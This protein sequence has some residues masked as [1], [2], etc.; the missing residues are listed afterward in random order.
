[1]RIKSTEKS[2]LFNL[3]GMQRSRRWKKAQKEIPAI[4]NS[5]IHVL[6]SINDTGIKQIE[7]SRFI[8][9]TGKKIAQLLREGG[10]F[11]EVSYGCYQ[12][13]GAAD[14]TL[15]LYVRKI[16]GKFCDWG[17]EIY[18]QNGVSVSSE[19]NHN[20]S[21]LNQIVEIPQIDESSFEN[22]RYISAFA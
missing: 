19:N 3:T 12:N 4:K 21:F 1:M 10:C 20:S 9:E 14:Y 13:G 15:Q 17:F 16:S 6:P 5:I 2:Y 18:D 8:K 11:S 7:V 22:Q